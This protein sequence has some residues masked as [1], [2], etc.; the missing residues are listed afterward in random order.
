LTSKSSLQYEIKTELPIEFNEKSFMI[1]KLANFKEK[2]FDGIIGQNLLKPLGAVLDN[3][4]DCLIVNNNKI[5][6]LYSCPYNEDEIYQLEACSMEEND[7][8][9]L[10]ENLKSDE[11]KRLKKLINSYK[12]LFFK[13]GDQLTCTTAI[14]HE[15]VTKTDR[16]IFSKIY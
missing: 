6:F 12:D 9:K 10:Y 8:S 4:N 16:P 3:N 15:I 13:E 2:S 5:K 14:Q 1:W 7:L 11:E